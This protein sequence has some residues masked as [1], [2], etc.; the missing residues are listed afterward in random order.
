LPARRRWAHLIAIALAIPG[1][2]LA[3]GTVTVSSD[4]P[5][6]TATGG[7]AGSGLTP[8]T[9]STTTYTVVVLGLGLGIVGQLDAPMPSNTALRITL[10]APG[11]A[12]SV[13][14]V[15]LAMTPQTLVRALPLGTFSGLSITY[16]FRAVVEAGVVPT[17][18]RTVTFTVTAV[19]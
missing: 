7:L 16:E 13:G 9:N 6:L 3:Q 2:A 19:P 12:T 18:S 8:G 1:G 15:D 14:P 11:G 4:P 10:A 5:P 17:T